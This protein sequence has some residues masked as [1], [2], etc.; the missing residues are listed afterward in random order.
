MSTAINGPKALNPAHA[1]ARGE[2]AECAIQARRA[3]MARSQVVTQAS[4][5]K[6]TTPLGARVV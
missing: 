1:T 2:G 6:G 5:M 3:G 4:A